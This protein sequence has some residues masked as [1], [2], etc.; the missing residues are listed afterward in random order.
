MKKRIQQIDLHDFIL[1]MKMKA[2]KKKKQLNEKKDLAN[3]L[4]RF[5]IIYENESI[6]KKEIAE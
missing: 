3:R 4:T 2:Q 5:H 1:Y 6:G